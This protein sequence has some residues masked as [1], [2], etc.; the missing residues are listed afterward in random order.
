LE[1]DFGGGLK[2]IKESISGD[3]R[4]VPRDEHRLEL[5]L[6]ERSMG[7]RRRTGSPGR[8]SGCGRPLASTENWLT[9]GG[10]LVVHHDCLYAA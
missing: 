1:P 3:A 4:S 2:V 6:R 8:C 7:L 10:S 9:V 5:A